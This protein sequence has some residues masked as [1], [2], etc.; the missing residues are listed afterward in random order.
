VSR[1]LRQRRTEHHL[2]RSARMLAVAAVEL[3]LVTI[4]VNAQTIQQRVSSGR[5][6]TNEGQLKKYGIGISREELIAVLTNPQAGVR[7]LAASQLA[8]DK[9]EDAIPFIKNAA[10]IETTM[11]FA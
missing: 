8:I 4:C 10:S 2:S 9:D 6:P 11:L 1:L 3:L 7:A 5:V